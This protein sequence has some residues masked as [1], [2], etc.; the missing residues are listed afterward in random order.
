MSDR[1]LLKMPFKVYTFRLLQLIGVM[2]HLSSKYQT[3]QDCVNSRSRCSFLAISTRCLCPFN[4][5]ITFLTDVLRETQLH[6]CEIWLYTWCEYRSLNCPY[7]SLNTKQSSLVFAIGSKHNMPLDV[8]SWLGF[9]STALTDFPV[10]F[11]NCYS[12]HNEIHP[13]SSYFQSLLAAQAA[14]QAKHADV[15][16]LHPCAQKH[17]H[18]DSE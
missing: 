13:Q 5:K 8:Y 14:H 15:S 2:E 11:G 10:W 6:L 4:S 7:S 3:P 17:R 18:R 1:R 12:I 16:W 9:R